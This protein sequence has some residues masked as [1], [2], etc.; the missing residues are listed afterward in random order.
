MIEANID[1]S[2]PLARSL[3]RFPGSSP[4]LLSR[5][6]LRFSCLPCLLDTCWRGRGQHK[7][8][9]PAVFD[10]TSFIIRTASEPRVEDVTHMICPPMVDFPASERETQT[11]GL[12]LNHC[13][14]T[15]FCMATLSQIKSQ[16]LKHWS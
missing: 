9:R 7:C 6:S 15:L 3:T 12:D 4:W 11:E 16:P 5:T 13:H 2:G 10:V 8:Q 14:I 1:V